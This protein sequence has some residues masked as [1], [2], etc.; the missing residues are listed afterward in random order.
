[1][2]YVR[3]LACNRP[4]HKPNHLVMFRKVLIP[5]FFLYVGYFSTA[6]TCCSGGIPLSNNLGLPVTENGVIQLGL[7]YDYNNL[8]TLNNGSQNLND[9]SRLRT[10]HSVLIN[11]GYAITD[12]I[13]LESLLTWVNQ[14]RKISQ[15]GNDNLDQTSGIG[16]AIVLLKYNFSRI[17]GSNSNLNLGAGTKVP[18][19]SSTQT[20][21]S[22][23]LLNADLQPGSNAWDIILFSL[24]TKSFDFYPSMSFYSRIF[25]RSTGTNNSYQDDLSYKFGNEF[26]LF[27]GVSNQFLALETTVNPGLSL[28]YR[29]AQKD[30]IDGFDLAN[31]GGNWIFIIPDLLIDINPSISFV[32]RAELPIYSKVEGTQLTPSYRLTFGFIMRVNSKQRF[33]I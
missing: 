8:N 4:L 18:L 17:L 28:K 12:K 1:M 3:S 32:S 6:Q 5:I 9:D 16:D 21:E 13:S 23:I 30:S 20:N 27:F 25:Y 10:T 29:N 19:G 31:T 2:F 7:N 26:Q 24:I 11:I 14:R 22:G 15:F 33:T